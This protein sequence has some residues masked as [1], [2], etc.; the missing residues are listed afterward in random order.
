MNLFGIR[1]SEL[2]DLSDAIKSLKCLKSM[3]PDIYSVLQ[4]VEECFEP[5][6]DFILIAMDNN[7]II[8]TVSVHHN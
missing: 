5:S 2:L 4:L 6:K 1:Q 3:Y 7:D 8:C